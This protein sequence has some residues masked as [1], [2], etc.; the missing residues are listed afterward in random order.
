M[1]KVICDRRE[2]FHSKRLGKWI[3]PINPNV[4]ETLGEF[5]ANLLNFTVARDPVVPV[6]AL[7]LLLQR[8]VFR[9]SPL[10]SL[11]AGLR[12]VDVS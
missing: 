4:S 5:R 9:H 6:V 3:T 7:Q 8:L 11:G 10:T 2:Q 1:A 12:D